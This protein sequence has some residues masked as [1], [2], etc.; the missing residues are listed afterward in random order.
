MKALVLGV[1]GVAACLGLT[2][3]ATGRRRHSSFTPHGGSV[4]RFAL[5]VPAIRFSCRQ[6]RTTPSRDGRSSIR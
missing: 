3:R 2:P 5:A 1:I 6:E 4:T